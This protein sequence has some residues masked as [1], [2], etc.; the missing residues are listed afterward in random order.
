MKI[1]G[2]DCRRHL[3]LNVQRAKL[4]ILIKPFTFTVSTT[5]D[6]TTICL[7]LAYYHYLHK[8]YAGEAWNEFEKNVIAFTLAIKQMLH[9]TEFH[10]HVDCVSVCVCDAMKERRLLRRVDNIFF[11]SVFGRRR[12]FK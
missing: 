8:Y 5:V 11:S 3:M 7:L 6:R 1:V 12:L 2:A 4:I 9:Q 10:F